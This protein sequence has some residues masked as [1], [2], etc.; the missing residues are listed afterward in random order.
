MHAEGIEPSSDAA[1]RQARRLAILGLVAAN[2]CWGWSFPTMQLC[3][4]AMTGHL[5]SEAREGFGGKLAVA[6]TFIAWRFLLALLLYALLSLRSQRGY[7]RAD[8]L[9]GVTTGLCFVAGL[10]LQ[11]LGLRFVAP[12]ISGFL[13]ALA[14]VFVPL[15]Q[16]FLLRRP[17]R[18]GTWLAVGLA[19]SGMLI[20]TAGGGG[21][22]AARAPFPFFGETLTIL[23]SVAFTGQILCLDRFG[24]EAHTARLTTVMFGTT[25]LAGLGVGLLAPGGVALYEAERFTQLCSDP[26]FVWT[27]G[28]IVVFSSGVAF[29]LMNGCQPRLAPATAG[30]LYT[31]EPVFATG[32]S[33][34]LGQEEFRA[35]LAGGG[36]LI[37]L[38]LL[39]VARGPSRA[40]APADS[41]PSTG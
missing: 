13:T 36:G 39:T 30:V 15:A 9:G 37:F 28:S 38:A 6:G 21:E 3:Q 1:A 20:L 40:P 23:G 19:S 12:S 22:A 14:V 34:L 18:P 33:I 2:F 11:L 29:H 16:T 41:A 4:G 7:T 35:S 25:A 5:P 24:R 27:L 8:V 17:L 32:F 31:L 10:F 26:T